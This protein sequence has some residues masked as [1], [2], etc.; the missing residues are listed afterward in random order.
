LCLLGHAEVHVHPTSL[1]ENLWKLWRRGVCT[2]ESL[3]ATAGTT[4]DGV[5][6]QLETTATRMWPPRGQR[7]PDEEKAEVLADSPLAGC[8][9]LLASGLHLYCLCTRC[10][11][12]Y[13]YVFMDM[14]E[15]T[16]APQKERLETQT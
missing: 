4:Y 15:H 12:R 8:R 3:L 11:V 5:F 1:F 9:D 13:G 7:V 14:W 16:G 6:W 10:Q 2:L